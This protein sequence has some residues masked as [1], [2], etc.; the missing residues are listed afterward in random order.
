MVI[1]D[2]APLMIQ[3]Y[4]LIQGF[5]RKTSKENSKIC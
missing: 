4:Q 2:G 1:S 5:F 3:L